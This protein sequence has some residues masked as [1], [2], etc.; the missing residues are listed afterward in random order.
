MPDLDFF[1]GVVQ[2]AGGI[3]KEHLLLL[4][5]HEAE[6]QTGLDIIILVILPGIPVVGSAF[7]AEGRF[8]ELRLLLPLA[9]AVGVIGQRAAEVTVHADGAVPV[10]AVNRAA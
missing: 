10:I 8:L 6:E 5:A 2:R 3:F 7:Q 9:V 1:G 4:R